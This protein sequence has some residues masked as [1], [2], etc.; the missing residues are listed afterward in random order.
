MRSLPPWMACAFALAACDSFYGV[1]GH[2]ARC[3]D[4]AALGGALVHLEAGIK[5]GDA[6]SAAD[7]SYGVWLNEPDGD[8]ASQLTVAKTGFRTVQRD[9]ANPHAPQDVCLAPEVG[10]PS[11]PR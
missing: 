5:R 10:A 4:H 6:V 8:G 2:V 9:V 1:R 3:A 7:G 11:P